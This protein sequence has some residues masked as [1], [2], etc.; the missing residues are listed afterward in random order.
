MPGKRTEVITQKGCICYR[1]RVREYGKDVKDLRSIYIFG[2]FPI[3][4]GKTVVSA[5]LCRGL[6]S[7]GFNVAP[8]K[9]RSGH[10]LWYQYPTFQK[11]KEEDR[12]FCEDIIRLREASGCQLPYEILNPIDALMAPLDAGDFL[13]KN[14]TRGMYLKQAITFDHLIV[15]RYTS[16]EEGET[17]STICINEKNLSGGVLSDIEYISELT[18]TAEKVLRIEDATGW[19]SIYRKLRP[20]SISTCNRKIVEKHEVTVVEGF[21]DAVC[22]APELRYK[23]V[24]GVAPGVV[25]FYDPD[26]FERVIKVKSMTGG[27]P[28]GLRS[29]DIIQFI[30]PE[31]IL[32]IP[33]LNSRD[34][35]NFDVMS[36]KL[37]NVIDAVIN[38]ID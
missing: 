6:L 22:P 17:K 8:F 23:A 5:A 24:L 11:C 33:P 3:S 20:V 21:N 2:L 38:R 9:P 7:R 1:L 37:W 34:L 12:L 10:N 14:D 31:G 15:E 29:K 4:P 30:K 13:K 36:H 26:D 28:M 27:D 19:A 16:L 32:S 35:I 18:E 25:A